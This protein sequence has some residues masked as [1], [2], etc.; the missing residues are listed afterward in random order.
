MRTG[1][2]KVALIL[3]ADERER[4]E[5]LTHRSRSAPALARRARLI[6]ACAE[7][8][9]NK[10][11]ARRLHVT[12]ATVCKWRGRFVRA[13]LDGLHDE[14]RPGAKRKITEE[15]IETVII[16]TLETT[17]RGATHWSTR[18][19]AKAKG[20]NRMA[21]SRIWPAFGLQPHRSETFQL[22]NDPLLV[23]KVREIVGLYLN[24]PE[25][26]AVFCVDEKPQIQ[27]LD[28]TQPLLPMQP[29]QVERRTHD[30]K[31][32]GT[33]TLFAALNAKTS[34]VITQF[35]QRHRSAQFR[36][37]LDLIEARVP[38]ALDVHIIMD[39]YSTHKTA[40]IRHWFAKRPRFHVHF[41]PTY[42]SWLSLVER[43]FA[44]LTNKQLRRGAFRSVTQLKAAIQKFIDVHH[45]DPK[46]FVWTK[47][48][49]EILASIARFAQR[50]VNAQATQHLS[51]TTV[52]GH[53]KVVRQASTVPCPLHTHVR[54]V[55]QP[56]RAMVRRT[57]QQ[58][59]SPW[60]GSH[61]KDLESAIREYIAVHNEDPTPFVWT[62][63]ADEI[64]ASMARYAQRTLVAHP[65]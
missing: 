20:L 28:R 19:M 44:E 12:P 58:T 7:G 17:P 36:E 63:S 40:L 49:D 13:R 21:I 10:V 65:A 4:L 64:L 16:R 31:R 33:T 51:R 48:A 14:P 52:T 59:D 42:A 9:D 18:S 5:S 50:T 55:D 2:P 46:A 25:H 22:S 61:V 35:H 6:L 15:Q 57:H 37:F 29:G 1:R 34:G 45:A 41:T 11:V 53:P 43:W 27:A 30:Y 47:S 56:G 8:T 62:K 24:P 54:F 38:L 39:N 26:A 3:T 23:E 32:H 60:R